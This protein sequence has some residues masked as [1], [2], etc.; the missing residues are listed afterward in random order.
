MTKVRTERS[1][2]D[3]IEPCLGTPARRPLLFGATGW[4]S[5][6]EII[7]GREALRIV[8]ASE[9][10]LAGV[11]R[12]IGLRPAGRNYENVSRVIRSYGF[13]T[14]HW[15]GKGHLRGRHNPRVPK[16]PLARLLVRDSAY[17]SNKL[18]RRLIAEGILEAR[19]A[20]CGSI[21]WLGGR[22]HSSSIM[23]METG[24]TTCF[25]TSASC[26]PTATN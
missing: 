14:Q 4:R 17:H 26:A 24:Q 3:G 10:S 12:G 18:R 9:M 16:I 5:G 21:E 13:S 23:L 25:V 11:L 2:A 8:V 6:C 20:S 1:I 15:T 19:S 7:D 22:F